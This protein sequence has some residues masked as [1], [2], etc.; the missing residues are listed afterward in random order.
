MF[1]IQRKFVE[2]CLLIMLLISLFVLTSLSGT[3]KAPTK[4]RDV[5]DEIGRKGELR[6]IKQHTNF[7][8]S[9]A[10]TFIMM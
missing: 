6:Q 9:H 8:L 5:H 1:K 7:Q 2:S 10:Q 4:A 3:A